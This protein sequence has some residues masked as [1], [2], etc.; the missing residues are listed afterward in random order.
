[1]SSSVCETYPGICAKS[2]IANPR[3]V[4][5]FHPANDNSPTAARPPIVL[6]EA[7]LAPVSDPMWAIEAGSIISLLALIVFAA[8]EEIV[9]LAPALALAVDQFLAS[10]PVALW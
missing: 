5:L 1:M 10:A 2:R 9:A 3:P 6:P 4:R 8:H 7:A